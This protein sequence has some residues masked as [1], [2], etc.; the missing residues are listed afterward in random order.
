MNPR[1]TRID[2]RAIGRKAWRRALHGGKCCLEAGG[3]SS[4]VTACAH[5]GPQGMFQ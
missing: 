3:A 5:L 4:R 2:L 1:H